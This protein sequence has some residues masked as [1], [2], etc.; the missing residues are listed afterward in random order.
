MTIAALRAKK[1]SKLDELNAKRATAFDAFK[2]VAGK[3]DFKKDDQPE[4]DRL[5]KAVEDVDLDQ[6]AAVVMGKGR[7][8]RA[9]PFGHK[10]GQAANPLRVLLCVD[11][12]NSGG[13]LA[14]CAVR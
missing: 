9:C 5:K 3:K 1:A 7:R 14:A 4:Y 10:T 13:L 6:E 12:A 11:N 2:V 8:P